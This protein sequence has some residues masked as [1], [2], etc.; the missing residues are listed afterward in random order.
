M[1][2]A[3]QALAAD[4]LLHCRPVLTPSAACAAG[5]VR[6]AA[7]VQAS[8]MLLITMEDLAEGSPGLAVGIGW[9]V[10]LWLQIMLTFGQNIRGRVKD[11]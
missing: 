11:S 1:A 6:V 5:S 7:L 8:S 3:Q 10:W 9:L 4:Y 2:A